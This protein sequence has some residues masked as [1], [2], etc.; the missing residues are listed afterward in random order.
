MRLNSEKLSLLQRELL[1]GNRWCR[2]VSLLSWGEQQEGLE[3]SEPLNVRFPLRCPLKLD[4]SQE[5]RAERH[6]P[7]LLKLPSHRRANWREE[8]KVGDLGYIS[9]KQGSAKERALMRRRKEDEEGRVDLRV[10]G[11]WG[12]QREAVTG[13]CL[14]EGVSKR[15]EAVMI[16]FFHLLGSRAKSMG[17]QE[18]TDLSFARW[19][20]MNEGFFGWICRT[21]ST[22][23]FPTAS[24]RVPQCFTLEDDDWFF[25][26]TSRLGQSLRSPAS[27][28]IVEAEAG[29]KERDWE[30]RRQDSAFTGA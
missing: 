16:N 4:V 3:S 9:P 17:D 6:Q 10:G 13:W 1:K 8:D 23:P 15:V 11:G 24:R 28:R 27:M 19:G 29:A 5:L 14:E 26:S 30:K 12:R 7:C 25:L 21:T 20:R 2:P 22:A 18:I